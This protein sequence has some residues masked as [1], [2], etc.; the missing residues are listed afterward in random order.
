MGGTTLAARRAKGL[1]YGQ[2]GP[3]DCPIYKY[4]KRNDRY[5]IFRILVKTEQHPFH[6]DSRPLSDGADRLSAEL[7]GSLKSAPASKTRVS[8]RSGSRRRPFLRRSHPSSGLRFRSLP[9]KSPAAEPGI[10]IKFPCPIF[11]CN[12]V[13]SCETIRMWERVQSTPHLLCSNVESSSTVIFVTIR[14][15]SINFSA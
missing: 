5:L 2:Y 9:S 8:K 11:P 3:Y 4:P 1:D 15:C 10:P 12:I 14:Q 7:V 13:T 6:E